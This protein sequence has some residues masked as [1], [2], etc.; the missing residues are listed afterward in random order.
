MNYHIQQ[1]TTKETYTVRHPILRSGK[2]ISSCNFEGDDLE[3]THHFGLFINS[4]LVGVATFMKNNLELLHF[5]NQYQLRGMA[6]LNEFQGKKLGNYL[7]KYGEDFLKN[8]RIEVIWC[9]AR[10]IAVNFYQRNG[11]YII[12]N[13]FIIPEIGLHYR[14][15][16]L[17]ES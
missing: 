10:E 9:N 8:E 7:V 5:N 16:K 3:T 11:F 1:I 17:C 4:K 2:P 14:M 12:G 13:A 6:I 15:Y